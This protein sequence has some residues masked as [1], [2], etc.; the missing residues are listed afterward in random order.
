M[1]ILSVDF[2]DKVFWLKFQVFWQLP[3]ASAIFC[4]ILAYAGL[5]RLL[6]RR[7]IILLSLVPLIVMLVIITNDFHHLLWTGFHMNEHVNSSAG[8]LYWIFIGYVYLVGLAN[9]SILA[10]VALRS[11][12][13]RWPVAIII[14]GQIIARIG[15]TIDKL[16]I[17]AIGPGESVL[18]TVGIVSTAY[19]I[20]IFRF[21]AIDP[22]PVART[23]V[24]HQMR[25]GMFIIDLEGHI[26]DVNPSAAAI[27]GIPEVSLRG[28]LLSEV[29]PFNT[30]AILQLD[31]EEIGQT[32]ITIGKDNL[33]R[34]YN[35][36]VTSLRDRH[37]DLIGKLLL[38]HDITEQKRAQTRIL[39]QQSVVATLQERERLA[40]ELHDIIGQ[41]IGYVGI[42]AQTARKYVHEGNNE[43]AKSLLERLVKVAKDT[44]ADVRE[45]ILSLRASSVQDWSF[46]P[47]L[48]IYIDNFQKNHGIHTELV[49][50]DRIREDTFDSG[51][52]VQLL[53]VIQEALTNTRKHSD[54]HNV[55][56]SIERIGINIHITITDDGRGFDYGQF[57]G[58]KDSH[59]GLIFMR[60]RMAQIDGSLEIDSKAGEGTVVKLY[61]PV[62]ENLEEVR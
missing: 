44:H 2:S 11:P 9:F 30:S 4:F 27:V 31:S 18:L 38:L 49:L 50:S 15:Y 41:V 24:L 20:A 19:A 21:H 56:V 54:A 12:R 22:I 45:S 46:I 7:N 28:K 42:Q 52:G 60:E 51:A 17:G 29:M 39:E 8:K 55:K 58:D 36:N 32:E 10:W 62:R 6:N 57:D 3:S 14:S 43:K 13:Y 53:R 40:R 33:A 5:S 37:G 35:L 34:Q 48:K 59:F 16:D 25:E 23:A 26:I 47:A 61:V 1:G